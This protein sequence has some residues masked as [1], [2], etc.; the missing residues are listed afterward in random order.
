MINYNF[1]NLSKSNKLSSDTNI[2]KIEKWYLVK[3]M[4]TEFVMIFINVSKLLT[5]TQKVQEHSD[6]VHIFEGGTSM[7][8]N[9]HKSGEGGSTWTNPPA[10]FT[11]YL[12]DDAIES[13]LEQREQ[14]RL[15]NR[16]LLTGST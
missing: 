5:S 9:L 6:K 1:T 12:E 16:S 2:H 11:E 10:V 7:R 4:L 13:K 15:G 3:K 8:H 14:T